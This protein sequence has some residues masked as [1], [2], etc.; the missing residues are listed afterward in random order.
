MLECPYIRV[1]SKRKPLIYT[2]TI[3]Q[4]CERFLSGEEIVLHIFD[5]SC[6][7]ES[8]CFR[9]Y[10]TYVPRITYVSPCIYKGFQPSNGTVRI[11]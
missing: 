11:I 10:S 8:P 7:K 6:R 2:R 1:Y 4:H 9:L 5:L 3:V